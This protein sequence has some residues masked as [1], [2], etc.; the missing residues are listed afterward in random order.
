MNDFVYVVKSCDADPVYFGA[1]DSREEAKDF[2]AAWEPFL[3]C[4]YV[5]VPYFASL[6]DA[7]GEFK[8]CD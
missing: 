8:A 5:E 4:D 3:S 2:A 1:F 6:A 7:V